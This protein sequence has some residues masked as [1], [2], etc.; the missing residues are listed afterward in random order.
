MTDPAPK[1]APVARLDLAELADERGEPREIMAARLALAIMKELDAR[2]WGE[3]AAHPR[4][5]T[6][7]LTAGQRHLLADGAKYLPLLRWRSQTGLALCDGC[8]RHALV[9][10]DSR[11]GVPKRCWLTAGCEGQI[12]V[13]RVE[14]KPKPKPWEKKPAKSVEGDEDE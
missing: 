2:T 8:G 12:H 1:K 6:I 5:E 13:A 10:G 3:V 9:N 7:H 11:T 14:D 4:R